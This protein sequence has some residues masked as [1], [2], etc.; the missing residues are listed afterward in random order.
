MPHQNRELFVC[1]LCGYIANRGSILADIRRGVQL[2]LKSYK[3]EV[4]AK[5]D[6]HNSVKQETIL[7]SD[8]SETVFQHEASATEQLQE[9]R[10]QIENDEIEMVEAGKHEEQIFQAPDHNED[11]QSIQMGNGHLEN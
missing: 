6:E 2:K 1:K 9:P 10:P 7:T 3:C 11:I 8:S 4:C 5:S